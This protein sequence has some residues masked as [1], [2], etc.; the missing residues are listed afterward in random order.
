MPLTVFTATPDVDYDYEDNLGVSIIAYAGQNKEQRVQ[1]TDIE[2]R[3]Y[4]WPLSRVTD[5]REDVDDFFKAMYRKKTSFL[6]RDP[7]DNRVTNVFLGVAISGQTGF[8]LPSTGDNKRGYPVT[9]AGSFTI[10]VG[11]V[12]GTPYT[13]N[14]TVRRDG[15]RVSWTPPTTGL[16]GQSIMADYSFYRRV[17]LK[18][19]YRWTA[20]APNWWNVRL[21]L[22]E[23]PE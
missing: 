7:K 16:S 4:S 13:S 19:D 6:V 12:G 17:R 14:L 20:L 10:Y 9:T 21:G 5:I 8:D 1:N 11:G 18:A 2:Y 22:Q 15:R 23:V 3:T